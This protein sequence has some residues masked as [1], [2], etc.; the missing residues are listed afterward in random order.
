MKT[1]RQDRLTETMTK[2]RQWR[3][4]RQQQHDETMDTCLITC[5]PATTNTKIIMNNNNGEK[6]EKYQDDMDTYRPLFYWKRFI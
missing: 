1:K 4:I 2:T 3:Q 6:L 5:V